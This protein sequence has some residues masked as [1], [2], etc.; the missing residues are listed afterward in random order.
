LTPI[1]IS[2]SFADREVNVL[3]A[4]LEAAK[5]GVFVNPED[6]PTFQHAARKVLLMSQKLKALKTKPR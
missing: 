2:H 5:T 4:M 1:R 6:G 3:N